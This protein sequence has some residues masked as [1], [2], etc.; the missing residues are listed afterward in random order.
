MNHRCPLL[1]GVCA[2]SLDCPNIEPCKKLTAQFPP[3]K[4]APESAP[5]H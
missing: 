4:E 5:A 2:Y 1:G 3:R